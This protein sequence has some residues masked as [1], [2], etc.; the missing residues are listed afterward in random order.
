MS[1]PEIDNY[2][3]PSKPR[4]CPRCHTGVDSDDDG[5]CSYCA[6]YTDEQMKQALI[7]GLN[8]FRRPTDRYPTDREEAGKP[9]V[10]WARLLVF[11]GSE[12][13]L[14]WHKQQSVFPES[15]KMSNV[16]CTVIDEGDVQVMERVFPEFFKKEN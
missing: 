2:V 16:T 5:N 3:Q 15:R 10:R 4:A 7:R 8:M 1:N 13:Q 12:D 14:A 9:R 6:K 11:E